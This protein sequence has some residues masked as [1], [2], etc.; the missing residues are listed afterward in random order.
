MELSYLIIIVLLFSVIQ[1]IFGVGLLLFGT[2]T[3]L[4][5]GYS[6]SETLW[7]LLP[8]SVV[9][10]LIQTIDNFDL[11]QSKKKVVC[12]TI[13]TMVFSLAFVVSFDN[14]L[15]INK[16]VGFFLLFI[17][18]LKFSNRI[19]KY[20]LYFAEKKLSLY[21]TFIGFVHGVS[22]MG[23]GPL[24]ILMS[25]IY[26]DKAK[27]RTN[28][29]FIYLILALFQLIVLFI[30]DASGLKYS[31]IALIL[32]SLCVYLIVSKYI[33]NK[34]NDEKYISLINI[35]IVVYGILSIVKQ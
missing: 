21:Y 26:R 32:T 19:Q 15:D 4:I 17:G 27:I 5:I 11:V 28:I 23:G 29:A 12:F 2:P 3:L 24:S 30:L 8:C 14:I 7:I 31:T 10:S 34:V 22:N 33:A 1:S 20:L 9:I 6:Y 35:L 13:P 18:I 25:T 16:I